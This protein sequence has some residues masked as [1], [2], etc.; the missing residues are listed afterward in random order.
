MLTLSSTQVLKFAAAGALVALTFASTPTHAGERVLNLGPVG[1]HEPILAAV[2]NKQIVAFY[3]PDGGRCS[4]DAVLWQDVEA[5]T[6]ARVRV[7]LSPGE[8]AELNS[9]A[10][11]SLRLQCG[12]EARSLAVVDTTTMVSASAAE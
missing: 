8:I 9:T 11:R 4:I 7:S 12:V 10:N 5:K 3:V 2:G 1:P 6:A